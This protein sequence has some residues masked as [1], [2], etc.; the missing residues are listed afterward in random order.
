M[1]YW[2]KHMLK[3]GEKGIYPEM[4]ND[5]V[6]NE[7]ADLGSMYLSRIIY[8]ASQAD[9]ILKTDKYKPL[10]DLALAQLLEFKNAAGGY[11]W[12]RTYNMEWVHDPDNVNMAQAFVIYG[13][14]AYLQRYSSEAVDELLQEQLDFIQANIFDSGQSVFL[15]GFDSHWQ[16]QKEMTVSFASH[17]H[18]MEAMV[19][20]YKY[21]PEE[22][23][24]RRIKSLIQLILNRFIDREN[25]L[26]IHRYAQ[27]WKVLP[28]E[29]WAGH[30]AECGWVMLQAAKAIE[31]QELIVQTGNMLVNLI[32]AVIG[33]AGDEEN[34]GYFN[35]VPVKGQFAQSKSW[36]PQAE[37]ALGLFNAYQIT[38]NSKY[39][40]LAKEQIAYIERFFVQK[41]GEWLSEISNAGRKIQRA[42]KIFFWKSLYHTV[43]YYDFFLSAE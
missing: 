11:Y 22:E 14:S 33:K 4:S 32:D 19:M 39:E 41:G 26:C 29:N 25:F 16:R 34:G 37:I 24:K 10:A 7:K 18:F 9:Q 30:N 21:K 15:D 38:G 17:F 42:P 31:D 3:P 36:W 43:R 35:L 13:L 12:A 40:A 23:L 2:M 1:D 27:N 20:A 6:P 5:D 28:N 8:G